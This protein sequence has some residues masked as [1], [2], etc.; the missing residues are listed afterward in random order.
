MLPVLHTFYI[1]SRKL[2]NRTTRFRFLSTSSPADGLGAPS[3]GHLARQLCRRAGTGVICETRGFVCRSHSRPALR[4]ESTLQTFRNTL[5]ADWI[6]ALRQA[7]GKLF[8]GMTG[9]SS[10]SPF[11]MTPAPCYEISCA[12]REFVLVMVRLSAV[13]LVPDFAIDAVRSV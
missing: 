8:A 4:E 12:R 10:G 7:Q 6:P 3:S 9:G 2:E 11:Q 13:D 5:S 1:A